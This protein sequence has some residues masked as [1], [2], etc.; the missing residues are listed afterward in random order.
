MN[1]SRISPVLHFRH[2][3]ARTKGDSVPW[4]CIIPR[5]KAPFLQRKKMPRHI[6]VRL[7]IVYSFNPTGSLSS[8]SLIKIAT[9]D[10]FGGILHFQTISMTYADGPCPANSMCSHHL[11]QDL[12]TAWEKRSLTGKNHMFWW[13][14]SETDM[15]FGAIWFY[16]DMCVNGVSTVRIHVCACGPKTVLVKR[17][18]LGWG[19]V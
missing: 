5:P 15:F 13:M 3:P 2:A 6:W 17:T 7:R 9:L 18:F 14:L 11:F 16:R 8:F 1:F 4:E 10:L 12:G 19:G